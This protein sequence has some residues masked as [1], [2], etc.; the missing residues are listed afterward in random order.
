L[1]AAV[2]WDGGGDGT[3][4]TDPINWSGNSLPQAAD[5]VT[6]SVGANPTIL[7]A[8]G[9]QSIHSLVTNELIRTTGGTLAVATTA[10]ASQSVTLA[11]GGLSGGAWTFSGG[12]GVVGTNSGGTLANVAITGGD[13]LLNTASAQVLASGTTSFPAAR[14]QAASTLQ[15][16]SGYV[17][18][19]LV[20]AEGATTGQR[21][22]QMAVGGAGTVTFAA[23][24]VVRLAAGCGGNLTIQNSSTATL[25]NNGTISAEAT[26]RT[27]TFQNS[28]FT[29]NNITQVTA[30][31]LALSATNWSNP[32]TITAASGTT[33]NFTDTWSNAGTL[34]VNAATLN[35]GGNFSTSA[36]TSP[37]SRG[38][39]GRSTS[40]ERSTTP[41]APSPSTPPPEP[42]TC[43]AARSTAA[44]SPRLAD[45]SWPSPPPAG[46]SITSR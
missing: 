27:L 23:G 39:V 2:S 13:V 10:T 34:S 7:I 12:A 11:T 40:P 41:P 8:S 35:L 19:S 43:W 42:G 5:D 38:R 37:V 24:A 32:G 3:N 4:W 17:L 14:L 6:I 1:L 9:T 28:T 16:A 33:V 46:R 22:I 25:V 26:G 30:G 18:N 36:S 31:T 45:R 21:T 29:N 15:L 20:V 44:R